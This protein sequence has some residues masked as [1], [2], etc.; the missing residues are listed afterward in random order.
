[1][2]LSYSGELLKYPSHYRRLVERQIYLTITRSD[3][4]YLV[5]VLS[6]F[7]HA[8]RKPLIEAVFRVLC[9]LKSSSGQ[10]LFFLLRMIYPC[11]LFLIQIGL[12]PI[13]RKSIVLFSR[14][15]SYFIA[16]EK[17]KKPSLSLA[18]AD[19]EPWQVHTVNYAVNYLNYAHY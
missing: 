7:M 4:T 8:H 9:Y 1:M 2:K 10:G 14:I 12:C 15:F 18:K 5:H 17:T 3:I 16:D 6:R 13:S 19:I 11:E